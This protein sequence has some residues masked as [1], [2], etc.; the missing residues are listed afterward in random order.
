[1]RAFISED[2]LDTFEGWLRYQA[3]DAA[4]LAPKE[5][6]EWR[7][8]FDDAKKRS[9]A[10]PK[11]GLMKL[12]PIP[13]EYRFAVAIQQGFDL[14]LTLWVRRSRRG[15]YFVM[16]PR[17]NRHWDPHTSYHLDGNLHVKSFDRKILPPQ[18][19]QALTGAFRGSEHIGTFAG[20]FPNGIGAIC[21]PMAFSGVVEV[22][23]GVLG[24]RH[25]I[26]TVDLVE[27]DHEPNEYP[28]KQIFTRRTFCDVVPWVVIT[29][30]SSG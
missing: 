24:P 10:R 19:R 17:G 9:V 13:G 4:S 2:D 21:D 22:V 7:R 15:E 11:V 1:M 20:H 6:S 23:P 26:V 14:W 30:G 18:K 8:M 3:I 25:G 29:V 28:W 27:P 12:K 16:V 5:L